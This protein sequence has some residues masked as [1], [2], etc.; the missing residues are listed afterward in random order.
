VHLLG[1][2][3]REGGRRPSVEHQHP[4]AIRVAAAASAAGPALVAPGAGLLVAAV[5]LVRRDVEAAA[6]HA[7]RSRVAAALQ[8]LEDFVRDAPGRGWA[9]VRVFSSGVGAIS[10]PMS[11]AAPGAANVGVG[12]ADESAWYTVKAR[13]LMVHLGGYSPRAFH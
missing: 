13:V 2:Q 9:Q 6:L 8:A 10:S 12:K 1:G 5:V 7:R 3:R 4:R 11:L